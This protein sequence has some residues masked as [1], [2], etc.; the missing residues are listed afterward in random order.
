[1]NTHSAYHQLGQFIVSFQY[2]EETVNELIVLM[3]KD[4]SV[5]RILINDLEYSKRLKAANVLF[6]HFIDL[7]N[8][9]LPEM[10]AE[11]NKLA[12]ELHKLGERRNELVHSRYNPWLDINGKEGL[13]RTNSKLSGS[14]G[15]RQENEEELQPEAFNADLLRLDVAAEKLEEFRLQI[16]DILHGGV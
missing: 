7:H 6:S 2:L 11:F 14:K 4:D 10:K 15:K 5:V 16:I 9:T 8:N 3:A 12:S 1:M 13:L